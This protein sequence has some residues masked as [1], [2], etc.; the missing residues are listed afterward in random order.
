VSQVFKNFPRVPSF[1]SI[2]HLLSPSSI[3]YLH[4]PSF[5]SI[6]HLHL[7]F[8]SNFK[9][10]FTEPVSLNTVITK[11]IQIPIHEHSITIPSHQLNRITTAKMKFFTSTILLFTLLTTTFAL[12]VANLVNDLL[13]ALGLNGLVGNG[14]P[15]LET[16][17]HSPQ[18]ASVNNGTYLCCESTFNGD[19]PIVV[20]LSA[21]TD[22]PL[23][24]N[25]INGFVCKFYFP[26]A[27]I[28]DFRC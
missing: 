2:F 10:N 4:L 8:S 1:F 23:T 14:T 13:G 6:F 19:L 9:F 22:Y 12:P 15:P 28:M 21:A 26:S 5:I 25:S 24:K 27:P 7:H 16:T 20:D 18:C 17:I 3:F 11:S